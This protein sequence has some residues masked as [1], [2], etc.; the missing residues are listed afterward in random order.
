MI[1]KTVYIYIGCLLM[2]ISASSCKKFL[3]EKPISVS[4]DETFWKNESDANSAVA[5]GYALLRKSLN[6]S[7]GLAFYA[8]GDLPADEYTTT[9]YRFG[10]V[11]NINWSI[12]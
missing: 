2:M 8:Y 4:T 5:A 11:S 9:Q 1:M 3:D 10:D 6:G 7:D 12:S